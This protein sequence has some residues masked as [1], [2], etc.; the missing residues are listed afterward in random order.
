MKKVLF[1][2]AI[3]IFLLLAALVAIPYFFKD[4]IVAQVKTAA[5]ESLTA[6]LDFS[7]VDISIFR[8]F[9][10]LSIG[11]E[12]L[13]ITNGPGPFEGVKLVQCERLDVAVDL[14]SAIFGDAVIIK[15]LFFKKPDIKVYALSN[16][17]ANYDITK[18]DEAAKPAETGE[19]APVK[20]ESYGIEDGKIL[21][22]DR[23][24]DMKAE[25][26]GLDH[27]GSGEFTATLYDL[28][29]KTAIQKLSVNYGGVQYLRN[30]QADWKSTLGADM[31]NMKFS[32][33]ENDL[34]VNDLKLML[35]GWVQMPENSEDIRM[36][37]TFGTP[38]NTFKS[39]L[40]I[41][42]GAYT[43]DYNDVQA[44][45]TVQ[46][47]GFAKGTYNEKTY[48]A[49]K[50][51]FKVG[52]ADFKYPS[53]PLGVS[54][55]NVDA[56]IALPSSRLND[57]T[58]NIPKFSL[59]IGSNP[60]EGYF[61]LKTPERDP[62]VDMKL[63]GTLNLGELS[64]AF[65]MEGVQELAGILRANMTVK[66]AMSQIDQAKYDEVNMAGTF[67]MSGIT[68][69]AAGSPTVKINQL[70]TSITPQRVDIQTFD[71]KLGNSD[72]RASGS[73]DNLLAYFSTTKTMRGNLNFSSNYF[74]ANEWMEPAPAD[75]SVVPNDV[76]APAAATAAFDRWDFTVDGKIGKLK[77][78]T[79]DISNLSA[80]GHFTP[81]KMDIS[82]FGLKFGGTSDLSGS[83]QIINAW[84]YLFDNQTVAGVVNLNSTYFDLNQFMAEPVPAASA[85][86]PKGGAT[87]AE[88]AGTIPVPE[89]MDMTLN[90]NFGKVKYTT[91]DL[92]NLN[93]Q[94]VVKNS[95]AKL[96]DCTADVIGGQI[97]LTGDYN[98]QNLAK[99][100]FNM[101][102][103]LQNMGFREAFQT[104]ATVKAIAPIAQLIDGKFNT[105]LSMSGG[106]GKDMM[107]DFNTLS[108]AGFL[109][110]ISA[111]FNNFKPMNAIADKLNIGFLKQ[112]ELKNTKNWFEIKDGKVTVKPFNTQV[113]DVGLQIGG[114]H[115]LSSD[116]DYQVL[117]KVPR[118]SLGSAANSGL[119]LLSKEASKVGVSLAQ[120]EFINVRFDLTGTMFNPKVAM[121]VLG[122]DGQ[123]TLKEEASGAVTAV[124]D[125]AKDS[126]TNVANREIDKAKEK[127]QA[128]AD[129]AT[130]SLKRLA[131][132]KL[133]EATKAAKDKVGEKAGEV[134]GEQGQKKV[135]EVKGK[136]DKWDPFKKKK[137]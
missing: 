52:N 133:E 115:G 84:N 39:L 128:A 116:M 66:A 78:D 130:D 50:L 98:T 4:E 26:E 45:G 38:A 83:G 36:D 14:W 81:N 28:V 19:A 96:K 51:D 71:A 6:K 69:R 65:P 41:I 13:E 122:S 87:A 56:S 90:A 63:N 125:K 57:L 44:N 127:A 102:M 10:K 100:T 3:F 126:L 77:Y 46:F 8:H 104:F 136:L 1:G 53:L 29:M 131:D 88:A 27:T 15:G 109:E 40:S 18:P 67:G 2:I 55:I 89:N 95:V 124:V 119:D 79:Y 22:D 111:I 123:S 97:G 64:K 120:G 11:L 75:G 34:K 24:L 32:F 93:G 129:K 70:A 74:D 117:T 101:D 12:A 94:V 82:N 72:L 137:N 21:Y 17:Q 25:L 48:P 118:K 85:A 68:Y 7:D 107:P 106:L 31:A 30:A 135:D 91:Y 86:A 92:N 132:K 99:P 103:A 121:K 105:T 58:V 112:L 49:F 110:T 33:K 35:D 114:S 61:N 20:L 62:T 134:L 43:K 76:E 37:L 80:A 47:A 5:N 73:I 23:G 9:P 54:N 16:G 59:K 113:R 42:P 60:L 108:A